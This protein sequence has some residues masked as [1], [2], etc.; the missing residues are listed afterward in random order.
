MTAR[1]NLQRYEDEALSEPLQCL[2]N[3]D[4]M[5]ATLPSGFEVALASMQKSLRHEP[6]Q[7]NM[8]LLSADTAFDPTTGKVYP[9]FKRKPA[10]SPTREDL[11]KLQRKKEEQEVDDLIDQALALMGK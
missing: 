11:A 1:V 2:N 10:A 7:G 6:I 3:L 5:L 9:K 8:L 4:M